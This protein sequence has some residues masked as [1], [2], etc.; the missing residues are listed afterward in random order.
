MS[1]GRSLSPQRRKHLRQAWHGPL[2][3]AVL[4][5]RYA[6]SEILVRKFW[7][8]E[9]EA[10]RLP[11]QPTPRPH[12]IERCRAPDP[13][14]D[15]DLDTE[16]FAD[17]DA[18][19]SAPFGLRI[20]DPDPLL[21]ALQREH[22]KQFIRGA[23]DEVPLQMLA[24]EIN[25]PPGP[26]RVRLLACAR[27]SHVGGKLVDCAFAVVAGGIWIISNAVLKAGPFET[28]GEAQRIACATGLIEE[29]K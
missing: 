22:G 20:P 3:V 23:N 15:F 26:A 14:E 18:P 4:A 25:T 9:R 21:A 10:G 1:A 27:D 17:D 28:L 29:V 11:P 24:T 5:R 13:V 16:D 12:F 19:M 8:A 2:T 7:E 6:I